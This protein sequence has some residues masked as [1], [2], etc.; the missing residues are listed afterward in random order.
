[1]KRTSEKI[2][3]LA[4]INDRAK[5]EKLKGCL[6]K[7]D[8]VESSFFVESWEKASEFLGRNKADVVVCWDNNSHK[9][10]SYSLPILF[11]TGGKD[12]DN[13][14]GYN[15]FILNDAD[16]GSDL[17][18]RALNDLLKTAEMGG[19]VKYFFDSVKERLENENRRLAL[20]NENLK[21]EIS[22]KKLLGE[23][24]R[25][26]GMRFR[27]IVFSM[28]GWIWDID[29]KGICIYSSEKIESILGCEPSE[30]IDK[31]LSEFLGG[32]SREEFNRLVRNR[33]I[34]NELEWWTKN[35]SGRRVCIS[36]TGVPIISEN[37]DFDGYRGVIKDITPRKEAE[38]KLAELNKEL[39]RSN[40]DLEQFAYF[41]SH[42]LREP[43]R[44]VSEFL[45]LLEK[46]Y[47]DSLDEDGRSFIDFAVQG[48]QR[49]QKMIKGLLDFARVNT[50]GKK[51]KVVDTNEVLDKVLS[52]LKFLIEESDTKIISDKLPVLFAD[53]VQLGHLFQNLIS[54]SIKFKRNE[55]C[56]IR[57][58]TER[59][60]ETWKFTFSDNGMGFDMEDAERIFGLFESLQNSG[61]STGLGLALCKRI[62]ER[63][64]G[65]IWAK[66]VLGKGTDIFFTMPIYNLPK[67]KNIEL[68]NTTV[69]EESEKWK[70][71]RKSW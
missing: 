1:M 47:R 11:I 69:K 38:E 17:M 63:H 61:E 9:R 39:Y 18:A 36:V 16:L 57:I 49:M 21:L 35:K 6:K 67:T 65:R 28:A 48:A 8:G 4:V 25:E 37:G 55:E 10:N 41:A 42:D 71:K 53:E 60:S 45:S 70:V 29:N 31:N 62:V 51:F 19:S 12:G 22:E 50:H 5:E 54:N 58:K 15:P 43:L 2:H 26:S 24:L 13:G 34:I 68:N 64:G 44:M 14:A 20:E 46:R 40:S 23:A 3:V 56:V 32:S 33:Q 27:D 59:N 7:V 66:S 52:D 30:I